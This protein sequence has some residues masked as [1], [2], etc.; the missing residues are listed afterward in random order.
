MS[1]YPKGSIVRHTTGN[2]KGT[3]LNVFEQDNS[4]AGYYITWDDGNHSYHGEK[5]LIWANID[6][7]GVHNRQQSSK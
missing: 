3:V 6:H 1:R 5:E 7:P 2:I 4:A